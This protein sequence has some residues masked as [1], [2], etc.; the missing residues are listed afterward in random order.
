MDGLDELH[1][2]LKLPPISQIGVIVS[3]VQKAV[4]R[5]SRLFGVGPFTIY[6]FEPDRQWVLEKPYPGKVIL[7][8]S[9]WG[10]IELELIQPLGG[11]T[12]HTEFLKIHGEG[13]QHFGFN[14]PNYDEMC[15]RFKS[16]GFEPIIRAE[17]YVETYKGYVKACSFNTQSV[18]GIV[19]EILWKSWLVKS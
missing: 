16:A 4:G 14:V 3:D 11:E 5:Y 2:K 10:N 18:S 6:E 7:G 17:S 8:K 1:V 13:V 12:P 9:M 19:F 15:N